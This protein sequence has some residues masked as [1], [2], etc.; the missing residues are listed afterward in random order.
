MELIDD[1][2][3]L[4]HI[5]RLEARAAALVD[6]AKKEADRRIAEN[7]KINREKHEAAYGEKAALLEERYNAEIN[8]LRDE[9]S[10]TLVKY[11]EE[12][13]SHSVNTAAFNAMAETLLLGGT[14]TG[15]DA[16]NGREAS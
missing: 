11:R 13:A 1:K 2:D 7:E 6:E 16:S 15:C 4:E 5:L 8:A 3:V 12:L 14:S 9:Y 10:K